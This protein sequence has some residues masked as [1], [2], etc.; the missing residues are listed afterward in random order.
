MKNCVSVRVKGDYALFTRPESKTERVSYPVITPSAARGVL[1]AIYWH[2][3][4][5]WAIREIR[6]LNEPR[7][8][9]IFRNEVKSKMSLIRSEPYFA[10]EDRSQRFSVC[11]REVDYI[12][13]AEPIVKP[14]C[15]EHPKKFREL[16][17][18]RVKR[19]QCHHRP[20]LGCR[21]F[22]A[23]FEPIDG[24]PE[25]CVYNANLGLMLWDV[26]YPEGSHD[27][28]GWHP[29]SKPPF[30]PRFFEA[31]VKNGVMRVP[32]LKELA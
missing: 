25:P 14:G 27:E 23:E 6:I 12:I 24:A 2:P 8:F 30:A 13:V 29:S 11:L 18:R 16:F 10:D 9:G 1:E 3:Q 19:G 21:E 22:A 15:S 4:F 20:A 32:S 26:T 5:T 28:T 31:E 17:E 7:T